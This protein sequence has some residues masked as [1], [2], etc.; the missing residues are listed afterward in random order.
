MSLPTVTDYEVEVWS[1]DGLTLIQSLGIFDGSAGSDVIQKYHAE[2]T[3]VNT[4]NIIKLVPK[5]RTQCDLHNLSDKGRLEI[6]RDRLSATVT[7][8]TNRINQM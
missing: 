4:T 3:I 8:F 7:D 2:N 6:K 1:A 5:V